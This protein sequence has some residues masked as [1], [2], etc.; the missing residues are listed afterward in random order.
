MKNTK[1]LTRALKRAMDL[2]LVIPA[3]IVL[4]PIFILAA[5]AIYIEDGKGVVYRSK[6]IGS[7]YKKFDLIKFR[8][9]YRD[10]DQRLK[11][12][13]NMNAYV[14]E[15][16]EDPIQEADAQKGPEL[17]TDS[18]TLHEGEYLLEKMKE[19]K[20]VFNKFTND[21]RITK[22]GKFLRNTS[23]DE[24][25]QLFNILKGDM[26]L[27]GNR[28]LPLYEA[29]KLT[30]DQYAKRFMAPAGLTGLWQVTKRGKADMSMEERIELDNYYAEHFSIWLD[31]KII[32]K[33]FPALLQSENV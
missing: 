28:P 23:I 16:E 19:G 33:T 30:T 12:M 5:L 20:H 10:A 4:S 18:G 29:E 9:M 8:T 6:R 11:D 17:V 15:E 2:V 7:G 3:L 25:P 21:P 31:L 26:H 1:P 32:L 27:V 24:L 14:Q 22:V 13:A